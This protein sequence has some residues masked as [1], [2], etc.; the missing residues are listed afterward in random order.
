MEDNALSLTSA[1]GL[2]TARELRGHV[3]WLDGLTPFA[4]GVL[5]VASGIYTYLG[6]TGLLERT[7]ALSFFAAVAYS[8]AVSVGIFVFWSYVLRL[9]PSMD[10]AGDRVGLFL[11][12]LVGSAAIVAMSSWLNAAALAG[13]AAVE[14]HLATTVQSYQSALERAHSNAMTAQAL[15]RDV[16]RTRAYFE[17]LSVLEREGELSGI[18]GQ[19]AVYRLLRQKADELAGLEQQI[20]SQA[21]PITDVFERGNAILNRMR[22]LI[23]DRG[24][25]DQRSVA[26]AEQSVRLAGVITTLRQLSVAPLVQRAADDLRA[27][28]VLPELDGRTQ[29]VR[30]AQSA[31]IAA[32]LETLDI[33]ARSLSDA[34]AAVLALP[35]PQETTYTPISTADAVI[36]YADDFVPSWAGAIAIDLLPGVLVFILAITHAAIRGGQRELGLE[37]TMTLADLETAMMAMRRIE[38][39]LGDANAA[40]LRHLQV[41]DPGMPGQPTP[42]PDG[43]A[44]GFPPKAVPG[45]TAGAS[46]PRAAE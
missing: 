6:V 16:A 25:V 3:S 1:R 14:Q 44:A 12:T 10:R 35:E 30:G 45:S 36:R 9:L 46:D 17:D 43:M 4:L 7:G 28:V 20:A 38:S 39:R 23:A 21:Q 31:T 24:P 22:E 15:E 11:A 42:Q 27:S 5:A 40:A 13:A 34:A 29:D 8:I 41:R 26:F 19:G 33:R 32:A 18:G 37:Q 2:R